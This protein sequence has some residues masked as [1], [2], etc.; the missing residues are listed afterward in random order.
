VKAAQHAHNPQAA[1]PGA[2][3]AAPLNADD[4]DDAGGAGG[5]GGAAAAPP[6][7]NGANLNFGAKP[8]DLAPIE[9]GPVRALLLDCD[10]TNF[11]QQNGMVVPLAG[12]VNRVTLRDEVKKLNAAQVKTLWTQ[13]QKAQN[14]LV[15]GMRWFAEWHPGAAGIPSNKDQ[16]LTCLIDSFVSWA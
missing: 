7:A 15:G 11:I 6:P 13:R 3:A 8:V 4:A 14:A 9:V 12:T 5:G 1:A 16:I 10:G 2:A